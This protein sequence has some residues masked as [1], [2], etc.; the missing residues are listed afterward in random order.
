MCGISLLIASSSAATAAASEPCHISS[1]A[2]MADIQ[3]GIRHRGPDSY[4][5]VSESIALPDEGSALHLT[6][7]AA[8]L[9]IQGEATGIQPCQYKGNI[10]CW[11]GEVFG[12]LPINHDESDTIQVMRRLCDATITAEGEFDNILVELLSTI[13]GPYALIF[14]DSITKSVYYGRDPFGRRSLVTFAND[15]DGSFIISSAAHQSSQTINL[16]DD[17]AEDGL[18]VESS[19]CEVDTQG[20]YKLSLLSSDTFIRPEL[21]PWPRLRQRLE[22]SMI[23]RDAPVSIDRMALANRFLQAVQ[24]AMQR[25]LQCLHQFSSHDLM[26]EANHCNVGVLFSGGIDSVF[27]AVVLATCCRNDRSRSNKITIDLVNISFFDAESY[28]VGNPCEGKPSPD[29]LAAIVA[30]SELKRLFPDICWNLVHVDVSSVERL[31]HEDSIKQ[32]IYPCNTHMDLN[33]GTAFWF[34]TRGIGYLS[35]YDVLDTQRLLETTYDGTSRPLLRIGEE[36]AA[37]AVGLKKDDEKIKKKGIF[38]CSN[39][40][41]TGCMLKR[42]DGCFWDLCKNCCL[43]KQQSSTDRCQTH[44]LK[45]KG[46]ATKIDAEKSTSSPSSSRSW[47]S[48]RTTCKCFIV[49]IGADEQMAGYARHRTTFKR[50]GRTVLEEELNMD[51]KRLWLRNLGR[52]DRCVSDNGVEA[53][54]PFLDEE[55]VNLLQSLHIDEI[56][57]LS[58]GQGSGDKRI[59]R[60]AAALLGLSS[61]CH[62]LVKRAIQFGTRIAK[63]TNSFY[64]GSHRKGS[65][66]AII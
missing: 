20:I 25:R 62:Q 58:D 61:Q 23:D 4:N 19:W 41:V 26:K 22:R 11:N 30:V 24:S 3:H 51:L 34:A 6:F 28:E 31:A 50:G 49:G 38:P 63:Q 10:L 43:A 54:F 15:T 48:Y 33:I 40:E 55:V 2:I 17:D 44:K 14:Y 64:H 60:D 66:S 29:R 56:C 21:I 57:D 47:A 37:N 46:L 32:L 16:V 42:K 13:W 12:G 59:L 45:Q 36:G 39:H 8:V 53:W 27:L 18:S 65:G 1:T 5:I 35:E 9:H 7:T 52:D